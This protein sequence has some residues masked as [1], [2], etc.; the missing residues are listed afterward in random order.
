M[1]D[2]TVFDPTVFEA[3][4]VLD[5]S[6]PDAAEREELLR[7]LVGLGADVDRVV[8]AD[9]LGDLVA[10]GF[11]LL[12]EQGDLSIGDL[13]ERMDVTISD[14]IGGYHLVGVE[15]DD[16]DALLFDEDEV[17]F[18]QLLTGV[19][20]TFPDS[21]A[22]EILRSVAA[23]LSMMSSAATAA[24]V[25]TVEEDLARGGDPLA[26]ARATRAA[27]ELWL[28][29]ATRLRP[30][31][32][33]HLRQAVELQRIGTRGTQDRRTVLMSVGFV[34]LVGYTPMTLEMD[35]GELLAPVEMA[36]AVTGHPDDRPT[37]TA[38]GRR[39]L[40]GFEDPVEVV[41]YVPDAA[42]R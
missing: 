23:A 12:L 32:R 26:Q 42:D 36:G 9:A 5:R 20:S 2:P 41:S 39:L 34:D 21:A 17:A 37:S 28:E 29:L 25:G 22:R 33:H 24:F 15:V 14:V 10:V 18:V 30:L 7:Y 38:A 11:D 31:L 6:A 8:R 35:P 27:G 19:S 13:A 4:G 1:F 3:A 40:K 16:S